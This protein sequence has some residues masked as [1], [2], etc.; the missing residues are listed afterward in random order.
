MGTATTK[1]GTSPAVTTHKHDLSFYSFSSTPKQTWGQKRQSVEGQK[2]CT[3]TNANTEGITK[4]A[5]NDAGTNQGPDRNGGHGQQIQTGNGTY[6]GDEELSRA[7]TNVDRYKNNAC[8][9]C[10]CGDV[11][12]LLK[13]EWTS[14]ATSGFGNPK[15]L[16]LDQCFYYYVFC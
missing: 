11:D 1:K 4:E 2:G 14:V 9:D 12:P 8:K 3:D 10:L 15:K 6:G 7:V 5:C 16:N 13:A